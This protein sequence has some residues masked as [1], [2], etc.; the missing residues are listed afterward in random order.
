MHPWMALWIWSM[1][2]SRISRDTFLGALQSADEEIEA[3]TP[4]RT[5]TAVIRASDYLQ[6]DV[7]VRPLPSKMLDRLA[8]LYWTER[9]SKLA[10]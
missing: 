9:E 1:A 7:T 2:M 6:S 5:P 10:I 4:A 8:D 3:E